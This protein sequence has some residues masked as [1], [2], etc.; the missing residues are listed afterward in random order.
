MSQI[1]FTPIRKLLEKLGLKGYEELKPT[2]RPTYERWEKMLSAETTIEDLKKYLLA[3][4]NRL[5]NEREDYEAR[6]GNK[7]DQERLA[8]IRTIKG[9][10][11]QYGKADGLKK[12][13][14]AEIEQTIT[15]L[16]QKQ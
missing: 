1:N 11:G 14:E 2:E 7:Q 8:Q 10:L 9:M 13:A 5:R 3:E 4:L 12:Q 6:P 15:K 16:N